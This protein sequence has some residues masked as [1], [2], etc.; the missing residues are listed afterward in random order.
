[1]PPFCKLR[2]PNRYAACDWDLIS[3][4]SGGGYWLDHFATHL[5]SAIGHARTEY[6]G[7]ADVEDRLSAL[8]REFLSG[9]EARRERPSDFSPLTI[10]TLDLFRQ[11]LL[12]EFGVSDP[13]RK[14]RRR[15]TEEM[16]GQ[17]PIVIEELDASSDDSRLE[18]LIRG[19]FAGNIF[20]MG[21]MPAVKR[22]E[23]GDLDF[24]SVRDQFKVRP[25]LVDDF[26]RFKARFSKTGSPYRNAMF[27]I[28]NAGSDAVLGC[29]PMIRQLAL[30]GA[31]VTIAANS[32]PALNDIL[33]DECRELIARVSQID[34]IFAGLVDAE[35]IDVVESGSGVPVIDLGCVSDECNEAA[36]E[37]DLVIL[38]GMGRAVESNFDT[39]FTCDCLKVALIKDEGVAAHLS[40]E[41]YDAICRF[42][43]S[44]R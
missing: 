13:Y 27:F 19:L 22:Y 9:I 2:D 34:P 5:E 26:D 20:D 29:M 15:E 8:R 41:L 30:G 35:L 4:E 25:W 3:D 23:A 39:L 6:A 38:E 37:C 7:D 43:P 16:L 40:G 31:K 28:D 12:D 10:L 42:D 14:L 11:E 44:V 18:L 21:A 36:R 32:K 33:A 24:F 1:M 17:Y